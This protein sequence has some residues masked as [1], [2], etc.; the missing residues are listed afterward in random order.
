[1]GVRG[2]E[3]FPDGAFHPNDLIDRASYA[4]M[5]ED[6][7]MKVSGDSTLATKF[8]GETASSFPDLRT[9]LPYYNAV[10]VVTS[11]GIMEPK[12]LASGEFGPL[13]PV[14]GADSLL[15]IRKFSDILKIY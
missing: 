15:I 5:I 4:M 11:R 8:I 6:I 3:V 2:L 13:G 14:G 7:L 10:R 12:D 1:M 9:D